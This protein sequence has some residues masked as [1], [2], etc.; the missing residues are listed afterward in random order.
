MGRYLE[1]ALSRPMLELCLH[2]LVAR[3]EVDISEMLVSADSLGV[4]NASPRAP[5]LFNAFD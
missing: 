3:N 2:V 5:S 4:A 1:A